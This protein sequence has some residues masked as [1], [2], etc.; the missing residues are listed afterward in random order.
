MNQQIELSPFRSRSPP[1]Q[2]P[3]FCLFS[4]SVSVLSF[5]SGG[6]ER[7]EVSTVFADGY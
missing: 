6:R 7:S 1:P 4:T 3:F 2:L 5:V